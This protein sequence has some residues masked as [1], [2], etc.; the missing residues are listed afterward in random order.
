MLLRLII[1]G[2]L[3]IAIFALMRWFTRTAPE[4]VAAQLRTAAVVGVIVILLVLAATGR[5]N[6]LFA[7][8]GSAIS[9]AIPLVRR[10]V[11]M[12]RFTPM[13]QQV[14][15][16]FRSSGPEGLRTRLLHGVADPGTG[17]LVVNI[18]DGPF[19]GYR[20]DQLSEAQLLQLHEQCKRLDPQGCALVEAHLDQVHAHWRESGPNSSRRPAGTDSMSQDEAREVLGLDPDASREDIIAAHRRLIQKLHPDR[21]GTSYLASRINKAKD[22]LLADA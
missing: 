4:K 11:P 14:A 19:K 15:G 12:L 5:L 1:A 2:A 8:I 3:L 7:L 16:R 10:L 22:V 9:A 21:G 13:L 20:L 6:W 17:K 18:I